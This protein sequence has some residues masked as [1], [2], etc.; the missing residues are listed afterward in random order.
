MQM[1]TN[2][3]DG[4]TTKFILIMRTKKIIDTN[5]IVKVNDTNTFSS[6]FVDGIKMKAVQEINI[7]ESLDSVT[8]ATIKVILKDV[9]P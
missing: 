3:H 6:V 2:L 8:T 5:V 7:H 1:H 4:R 9:E